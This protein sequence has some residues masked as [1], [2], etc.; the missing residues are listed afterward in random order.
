MWAYK[1]RLIRGKQSDI[2]KRYYCGDKRK[3]KVKRLE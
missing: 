1:V 2:F 3:T